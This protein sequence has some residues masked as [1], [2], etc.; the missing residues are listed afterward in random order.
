V[1]PTKFPS[2][3]YVFYFIDGEAVV[4]DGLVRNT[5]KASMEEDEAD[6][7]RRLRTRFERSLPTAAGL[8][9]QR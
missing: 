6:R 3:E 8:R 4:P 5:E 2:I 7:E 1:R 9:L